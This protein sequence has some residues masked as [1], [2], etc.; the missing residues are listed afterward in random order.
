MPLRLK[1]VTRSLACPAICA[2]LLAQTPVVKQAAT[3]L[4][5][6]SQVSGQLSASPPSPQPPARTDCAADGSVVN[7]I[8]REP[9]VRARVIFNGGGTSYTTTTDG[10]GRWA[11]TNVACG[12]G[13]LTVSRPGFLTYNG[14]PRGGGI[15]RGFSLSP[16]SPAHDLAIE[17][18]PQAVAWGKVQDSDG[19]PIQNAQVALLALRIVDGKPRFQQSGQSMTNDLGEYRISSIAQ[20]KYV[21]CVHQQQTSNVVQLSTQTIPVDSCYPGPLEA[22]AASAMQLPAGRDNKVDFTVNQVVPVHVRG[23]IS[24]MPEGRGVGINLI[25]RNINSDFGG[26]LPGAVRGNTFDFRVPPGSYMVTAD[27]YE[28]GKRLVARVPIDV[29]SADLDNVAVHLDSGIALGGI[30]HVASQSQPPAALPPFGITLR[31]AEPVNN[32]TGVKWS[33]DHTT[34]NLNDVIPGTYRLDVFPPG[35]YYVKSVTLGGQDMLGPEATIGPGSGPIEITLAAD[36]GTIEGDVV[37]SA[38]QPSVAT[39]MLVRGPRATSVTVP[40]TGHFR[41]PDLGPGDY[42]I[43]AWDDGTQVQYGVPEWMRRYAGGGLPVSVSAGQTSQI[44]LTRQQAPE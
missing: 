25:R 23:T 2:V 36:G 14:A 43:Y 22:G 19:D 28:A 5:A 17:L 10:S 15:F 12:A 31:P 41:M 16:G 40:P 11:M 37:D 32:T 33:A 13:Q 34:F 24:G 3:P 6:G 35:P 8:T 20:G 29:G 42:M 39:V 7:S 21:V 30:V 9:V 27:Y 4:A 38:G 44:K 26:N 1:S 18:T